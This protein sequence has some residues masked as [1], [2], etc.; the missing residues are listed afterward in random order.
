[1]Q[2]KKTYLLTVRSFFGA[3]NEL[4]SPLRGKKRPKNGTHSPLGQGGLDQVNA[5]SVKVRCIS[6]FYVQNMHFVGPIL[7][8]SFKNDRTMSQSVRD[9]LRAAGLNPANYQ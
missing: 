3:K 2:V 9:L 8:N 4:Y 5:C 7:S 1:M 6:C